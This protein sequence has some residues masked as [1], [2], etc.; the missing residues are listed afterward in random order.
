MAFVFFIFS[1]TVD[2]ICRNFLDLKFFKDFLTMKKA[3]QFVRRLIVQLFS[4]VRIDMAHH[5]INVF[6]FQ[7]IKGCSLWQDTPDHFMGNFTTSFLIRTLGIAI[8]N[9][10]SSIL[11]IKLDCQWICKF[12]ST[13]CKDHWK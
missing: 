10:S 9:M 7:R 8:K 3:E 11:F 12:T 6:L 2:F 13:I 1:I 5:Q 4:C